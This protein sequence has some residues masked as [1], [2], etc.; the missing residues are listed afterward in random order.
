MVKVFGTARYLRPFQQ[1]RRR[2]AIPLAGCARSPKLYYDL[3][4]DKI[5]IIV[6]YPHLSSGGKLAMS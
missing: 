5:G 4:F 1:L 2:D 3:S 6:K